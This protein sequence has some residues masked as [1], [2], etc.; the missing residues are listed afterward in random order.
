MCKCLLCNLFSMSNYFFQLF[1][2][3]FNYNNETKSSEWYLCRCLLCN[4]F[5]IS[6]QFL[7]ILWNIKDICS[8]AFFAIC[9]GSICAACCCCK[10]CELVFL[11]DFIFFFFKLQMLRV[12]FFFF[13]I[14]IFSSSKHFF[15]HNLNAA[16][17]LKNL[18]NIVKKI[19]L[20]D[21]KCCEL[22]FLKPIL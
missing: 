6:L 19:L 9:C 17:F 5:S 15:L 8:G 21:F 16:S 11:Q 18:S 10:C 4:L 3:I 22:F 7:I 13:K 14:L 20:Q 12:S 1:F 2:N